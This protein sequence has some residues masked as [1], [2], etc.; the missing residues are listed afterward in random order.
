MLGVNPGTETVDQLGAALQGAD[1]P[2]GVIPGYSSARQ[3]ALRKA[4]LQ[5]ASRSPSPQYGGR[6]RMAP[7]GLNLV[8]AASRFGHL[9]M[10][11]GQNGLRDDT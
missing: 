10:L 4:R 3:P 7:L 11:F 9:A 2:F 5:S 1:T 8:L 6:H